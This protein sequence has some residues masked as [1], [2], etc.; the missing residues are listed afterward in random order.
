MASV[1]KGEGSYWTLK[2]KVQLLRAFQSSIFPLIDRVK[3]IKPI[4]FEPFESIIIPSTKSSRQI[5]MNAYRNA[6]ALQS[7][8]GPVAVHLNWHDDYPL[9][10]LDCD[11]AKAPERPF[12]AALEDARDVVSYVFANPSIYDTSKVTLSGF[13]AGG[14]LAL[15]VSVGVGESVR[16]GKWKGGETSSTSTQHPLKAVIAFYPLSKWVHPIIPASTVTIP[17]D[18]K[19]Y[20]GTVL[21]DWVSHLFEE[22]HW[23]PYSPESPEVAA[24]V[25]RGNVS[26]AFGQTGDFPQEVALITAEYDTLTIET[27]KLRERLKAEGKDVSGWMVKGVG[28]AWDLQVH[29]PGDRGYKEKIEAYDLAAQI[30]RRAASH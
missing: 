25:Q 15:G 6:A 7:N 29:S 2:L 1:P 26:P 19:V 30:I 21:P 5:R 27:E 23:F 8:V 22:A 17:K 28:H 4:E 12:P 24:V 20:P 3:G 18:D 16:L 14:N 10:V 9:V 13:S 11:Y